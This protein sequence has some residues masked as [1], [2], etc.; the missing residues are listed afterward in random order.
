MKTD[1]NKPVHGYQYGYEQHRIRHRT[2]HNNLDELLADM[3]RQTGRE[4]FTLTV[5]ELLQW[6][7]QQT[8]DPSD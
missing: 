4:V 1:P 2:L 8:I 3:R 6:S 5:A 7:H